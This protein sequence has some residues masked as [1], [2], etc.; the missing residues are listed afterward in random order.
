MSQA[1]NKSTDYKSE[2]GCSPEFR[3]SNLPKSVDEYGSEGLINAITNVIEHSEKPYVVNIDGEWGIGKTTILNCIKSLLLEDR[4]AGKRYLWVDFSALEASDFLNQ[5]DV[6]RVA[7]PGFLEGKINEA[8]AVQNMRGKRRRKPSP[9]RNIYSKRLI[10]RIKKHPALVGFVLLFICYVALHLCTQLYIN[11]GDRWYKAAATFAQ[12]FSAAVGI[13][14]MAGILIA[15]L[16]IW[17]GYVFPKIFAE[18]SALN[19]LFLKSSREAKRIQCLVEESEREVVVVIDDLDRVTPI[20]SV[21]LIECFRSI[22]ENQKCVFLV[23]G[24]RRHLIKGAE[25]L[26]KERDAWYSAAEYMEKA[27]QL[28]LPIPKFGRNTE[29][30]VEGLSWAA[31]RRVPRK[32]RGEL[33][34]IDDFLK[35]IVMDVS[36]A[37]PRKIKSLVATVELMWDLLIVEENSPEES[38]QTSNKDYEDSRFK[39]LWEDIEPPFSK[40]AYEECEKEYLCSKEKYEN[41]EK[42]Y[43][44]SKEMHEEHKKGCARRESECEE[45]Q[46]TKSEYEKFEKVHLDL[47]SEYE[48]HEAIRNLYILVNKEHEE[49]IDSIKCRVNSEEF[50][51]HLTK[52]LNTFFILQGCFTLFGRGREPGALSDDGAF[53]GKLDEHLMHMSEGIYLDKVLEDFEEALMFEMEHLPLSEGV[54]KTPVINVCTAMVKDLE[55]LRDLIFPPSEDAYYEK[56]RYFITLIGSLL[57]KMGKLRSPRDTFLIGDNVSAK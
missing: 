13:V 16:E 8:L 40:K 5:G 1:A 28:H 39:F 42:Q 35:V 14:S 4:K 37:N 26:I 53:Y 51:V 2:S 46:K 19:R 32:L 6:L 7:L 29:I 34:D 31:Q 9:P 24:Q 30:E 11:S 47:E 56:D 55:G 50:C 18:S 44:R 48:R 25:K 21:K 15:L 22:F 33:K 45:C 10:S 52:V 41:Y 23:V 27:I 12:F 49:A 17:K 3:Y 54:Q 36:R 43:L 20:E 57:A 38:V